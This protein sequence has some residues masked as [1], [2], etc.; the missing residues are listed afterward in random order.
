MENRV[1]WSLSFTIK[2]PCSLQIDWGNTWWIVARRL[3]EYN[4]GK[5]P[6]LWVIIGVPITIVK[7]IG[8]NDRAVCNFLRDF[9]MV[10]SLTLVYNPSICKSGWLNDLRNVEDVVAVKNVKL[11]MTLTVSSAASL[12]CEESRFHKL[13]T[14]SCP[15]SSS[16]VFRPHQDAILPESQRERAHNN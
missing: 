2:L 8:R 4:N 9:R 7:T 10:A 1:V 16:F 5:I 11:K 15:S 6:I 13:T 12:I 3:T 14:R